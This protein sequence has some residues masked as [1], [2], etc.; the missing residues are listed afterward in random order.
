MTSTTPLWHDAPS[1]TRWTAP[2]GACVLALAA[3]PLVGAD[4]AVLIVAGCVLVGGAAI[5]DTRSRG[6]HLLPQLSDLRSPWAYA[7]IAI[8]VLAFGTLASPDLRAFATLTLCAS[9]LFALGTCAFA[10][11]RLRHLSF[12]LVIEALIGTGGL[13]LMSYALLL[14]PWLADNID[15]GTAVI[16]FSGLAVVAGG[17]L[18][19]AW[20][21]TVDHDAKCPSSW[22]FLSC[23]GL[24][25]FA[26]AVVLHDLF[27]NPWPML[28]RAVVVI[29]TICILSASIAHP[30][31]RLLRTPALTVEASSVEQRALMAITSVMV[32][33]FLI[34]M[35]RVAAFNLPLGVTA[36][37]SAVLSVVV[38]AHVFRLLRKWGALEHDVHHDS[39]TGL[40]NRPFF[41]ARLDLAIELA[42]SERRTLAVMF[43]DLDRFKNVNDSLGHAAGNSLL[44][45]VA[46]RLRTAV[47]RSVTVARLAGDEF[48]IL[49]PSV[50]NY[51]HTESI[52]KALLK[53]FEEPFEIGRRKLY[54]TPSIG[55]AHYP[56]DGLIAGELLE[57]ADAAM[58]RAKERGRNTV[59]LYTAE[60]RAQKANRL[61]LESAL[62]SAVDENQLELFYQPKVNIAT[63]RVVGVEA[64]LRWDHPIL[65]PIPPDEF[66]PLAEESGLI[67]I[68][69]EWTLIEGCSQARRWLEQG[70]E[71]VSV[72]V[73]LSPRQFQLQRVQDLVARV[74]RVTHLPPH[75]LELELTENLALQDPEGVGVVIGDLHAMGVKCSI[76]DF[77][78]GYS[79]LGY[80]AQFSFD[81]I[82]IDRKFVEGI[83]DSGA[84]I[85][86]AVIAMAKGLRID[87]V[88]EGVETIAQLEFLRRHGCDMMQGYLF[89]RPL[90]ARELEPIL[91]KVLEVPSGALS[92]R[93]RT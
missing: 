13:A 81:A 16:A 36:M 18:V 39:L 35:N 10:W 52:A 78:V 92:S 58:Y 88:A 3:L 11:E 70:I 32:G 73:N 42:R 1:S 7:S 29:V 67:S 79:G 38:S 4:R 14:A 93:P 86:T 6:G 63:G 22:M 56:T 65:G 83:D 91:R 43:L 55:V 74:L 57:H 47:D 84:P 15:A 53:A 20:L 25:A 24:I 21:V 9:I 28:L 61:D 66:I 23:G 75:L 34:V 40:P 69:G 85:V 41:N 27:T 62:H 89:S 5:A 30:S 26:D 82:K 48:A 33:P 72:A 64:L 2:F 71:G 59:E 46:R 44:I 19:F 37:G 54:V 80:L 12:E 31:Q 17:L 76:D 50:R 45:Q 49:I 90:P 60:R 8:A 87:V 77:G 51:K 68:I